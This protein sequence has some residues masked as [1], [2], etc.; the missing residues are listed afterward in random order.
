MEPLMPELEAA[1]RARIRSRRTTWQHAHLRRVVALLG[2]AASAA[3]AVAIFVF[4]LG[5]HRASQTGHASTAALLNRASDAANLGDQVLHEV[6]IFVDRGNEGT[7]YDR[8]EGWLLPAD[9]RAREIYINYPPKPSPGVNIDEWIITASGRVFLRACFT[10]RSAAAR[11]FLNGAYRTD[12]LLPDG[13]TTFAGRR[14]ARFQSME[15]TN[16]QESVPWRPGTPP[17]A[18]ARG[19]LRLHLKPLGLEWYIDPTTARLVGIN[20][21]GYCAGDKLSSCEGP[22]LT[23]RIVTFQRLAPTPQNLAHLTG[24]GAP[25]GAR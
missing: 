8:D 24:P 25:P 5:V 12:A 11:S 21:W 2:A 20:Q 22:P 6:D 3:I 13:T 7:F 4:A 9:G 18:K 17:P 1:L 23:T 15:D 10:C 14:V 16:G 19:L